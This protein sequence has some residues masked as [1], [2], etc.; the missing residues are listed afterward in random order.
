MIQHKKVASAIGLLAAAALMMTACSSGDTEPP[1][2][3]E[4]AEAV[5]TLRFATTPLL[6][7]AALWVG[8]DQGFFEEVGLNVVAE[9]SGVNSAAE[10]AALLVSGEFDLG[11]SNVAN[12]A[13]ASEQGIQ[14]SVV[15]GSTVVGGPGDA[16]MSVVA[17]VDGP[18]DLKELGAEGVVVGV[19][20]ANSPTHVALMNAIDEA[21]G[22]SSLTTFQ[23]VPMSTGGEMI[24]NGSLTA[25]II[26]QPFLGGTLQNPELQ[27][28]G[29]AS[30]SLPELTPLM[31]VVATP[32]LI[33]ERAGALEKFRTAWKKASDWANDPANHD[34]LVRIAAENTGLDEAVLAQIPFPVY[35]ATISK[36]S[37]QAELEMFKKYG[38]LTEVPDLGALL[39]EGALG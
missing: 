3:G 32:K 12:L 34:E 9:N 38:A 29:S 27:V 26:V 15:T 21:G 23:A 25:S 24:A 5:E 11:L 33:E 10:G 2:S 30:E 36:E 28:I 35:T 17:R 16:T 8:I 37:V 13:Q 22:D 18:T 20:G 7:T 19:A 4:S 14:L 39:S 6:E 31:S 1:A